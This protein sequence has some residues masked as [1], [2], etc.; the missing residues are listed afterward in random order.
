MI[1]HVSYI[2]VVDARTFNERQIIR[3]APPN[4][5]QH[6]AGLTFTP[7]SK[8]AF[9]GMLCPISL[10]IVAMESNVLEFEID[11]MSRRSFPEGSLI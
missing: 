4:I 5:D 8:Y 10:K 2:N 7:D 6:I 3:V 1:K 11:T 9:V